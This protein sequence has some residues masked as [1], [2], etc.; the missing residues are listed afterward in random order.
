M[1]WDDLNELRERQVNGETVVCNKL[2]LWRVRGSD[3]YMEDWI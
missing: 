2:G 3:T 1:C